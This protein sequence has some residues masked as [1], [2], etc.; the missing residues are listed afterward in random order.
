[1]IT[2]AGNAEVL[3]PLVSRY[4]PITVLRPSALE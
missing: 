2:L 3:K 1:V 4:G